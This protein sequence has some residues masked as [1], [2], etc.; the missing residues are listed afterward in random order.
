[1]KFLQNIVTSVKFA[2]TDFLAALDE[3]KEIVKEELFD[4]QPA[5]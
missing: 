4:E 1:M 5:A 2:Y 3:F